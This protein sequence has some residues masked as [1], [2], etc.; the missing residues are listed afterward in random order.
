MRAVLLDNVNQICFLVLM[1]IMLLNVWIV[2]I[3]DSLA[4]L[5]SRIAVDVDLGRAIFS[6]WCIYRGGAAEISADKN[7]F[8]IGVLKLHE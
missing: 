7:K 2:G 4:W 3:V 8:K 6:G 1:A 5:N